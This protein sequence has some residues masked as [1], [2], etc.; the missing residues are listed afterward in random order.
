[1]NPGELCRVDTRNQ[2]R[3]RLLF[4]S[5]FATLLMAICAQAWIG[6]S[7][8]PRR[9]KCQVAP[10]PAYCA[11]WSFTNMRT[12]EKQYGCMSWSGSFGCL[13]SDDCSAIM[14][15][16]NSIRIITTGGGNPAAK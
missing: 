13:P 7:P 14:K 6:D 5:F 8:N 11:C 16:G 4:A 9:D 12:G 10:G 15:P 1:M 3:G 2:M